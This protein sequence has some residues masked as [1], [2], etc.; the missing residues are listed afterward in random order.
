MR[1]TSSLELKRA[2]LP[3]SRY[4]L[5]AAA[6][7]S[8]NWLQLQTPA[9]HD[10][11]CTLPV[12]L[13]SWTCNSMVPWFDLNASITLQ[14]SGVVDHPALIITREIEWCVRMLPVHAFLS[15]YQKTVL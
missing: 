14:I 2:E 7:V 10:S 3:M 11:I 1:Q 4:I 15:H 6:T 8:Y 5:L 13:S 12:M 9:A